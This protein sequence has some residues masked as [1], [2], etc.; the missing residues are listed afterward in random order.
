MW[1]HTL[2]KLGE[3]ETGRWV[4]GAY[5]PKKAGPIHQSQVPVR[6]LVFENQGRCLLR[7]GT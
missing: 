7:N 4:P 1:W 3:T 2:V 6:D 5:W